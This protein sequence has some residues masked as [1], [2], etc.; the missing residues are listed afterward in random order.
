MPPPPLLTLNS[1][2]AYREY[3]ERDYCRG[4]VYTADGIRVFFKPQK[5]GHAFYRNS[6]GKPGPK[7]AFCPIRASRMSWIK[8]TLE[9]PDTEFFMGWNKYKKSYDEVRRVSVLYEDFVIVIELSL[10]RKSEL[11]G[12]FITCYQADNSIEKIRQS[13]KWNRK[14]CLEKLKK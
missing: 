12:N 11:K 6:E 1:I 5:F 7:N 4:E 10:N 13:P 2:K 8:P 3:Y 14:K 9:H